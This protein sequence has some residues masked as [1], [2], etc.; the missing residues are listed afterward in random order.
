MKRELRE[1]ARAIFDAGLAAA[2]PAEQI[3]SLDVPKPVAGG[4]LMV[5]GAGKAAAHLARALESRQ[6]DS[7]A[8][9]PY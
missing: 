5:F 4:R 6:R 3:E 8:Y 9:P 2:D 1:E 7:G